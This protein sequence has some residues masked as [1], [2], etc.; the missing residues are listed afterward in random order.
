MSAPFTLSLYTALVLALVTAMLAAS[1][2]LGP[3]HRERATDDP[4][5]SGVVPTGGAR[6]RLSVGFYVVAVAFLVF[7]LEAVFLFVWAIAAR[8]L[9]WA[10]YADASVFVAVLVAAL[11]YLWRSG[12]LD[13]GLARRGPWA[14]RR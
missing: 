13:W 3:R 2:V 4:F 5:E 14:A 11:V 1:Y 9:G 12:A 8:E 6:L 7:D 10:G